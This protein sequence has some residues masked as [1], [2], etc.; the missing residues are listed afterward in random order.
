MLT[1]KNNGSEQ[2]QLAQAISEVFE[3]KNLR[4]WVKDDETYFVAKDV[5]E[6]AGGK[7]RSDNFQRDLKMGPQLRYP[8]VDELGRSQEMII[9]D[10][11]AM[12]K[13]LT[14]SRLPATDKLADLVWDIVEKVMKGHAVNQVKQELPATT[15]KSRAI[16]ELQEEWSPMQSMWESMGYSQGAVRAEF[17]EAA[18]QKEAKYNEELVSSNMKLQL[19][20]GD[21]VEINKAVNAQAKLVSVGGTGVK[22]TTLA[23]KLGRKAKEVNDAFE[24]LGWAKRLGGGLMVPLQPGKKFCYVKEVSRGKY[25]GM[26]TIEAWNEALVWSHLEKFFRK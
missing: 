12:L 2:F 3:G 14:V 18:V 1:I 8:I 25:L 11:K 9:I 6:A 26:E 5:V 7:W 16:R 22:A 24:V 13:W 23:N 10:Q 19:A 4:Y 20:A 17:L 21:S 15:N